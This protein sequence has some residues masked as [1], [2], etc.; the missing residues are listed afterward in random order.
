MGK[1][2]G[3]A[4]DGGSQDME[5][6]GRAAGP[7]RRPTSS[8]VGRSADL[9]GVLGAIQDARLVTLTGPGGVGKTR[10]A[11]EVM[12]RI[13][14]AAFD[15]GAV[16]DLSELDDPTLIASAVT[17]RLGLVVP[18]DEVSVADALV[19]SLAPGSQVLVL[20]NCEHL[21]GAVTGLVDRLLGSSA[22]LR[23]LVTSRQ[24]LRVPGEIVWRVDPLPVPGPD[25]GE[26]AADVLPVPSGGLFVDRA[27]AASHRF[28]LD[29]T[30]APAVAAICRRLDGLPLAIELA[31]AWTSSLSPGE[32]DERLRRDLDFLRSPPGAPRRHETLRAV[33]A[34]SY[35]QLT[36]REKA[37][38]DR[39]GPFTGFSADAAQ[40][41]CGP[42]LGDSDEITEVLARLVDKSLVVVGQHGGRAR[43]RRLVAARVFGWELLEGLS[44]AGPVR[45]RHAEWFADLAEAS[46]ADPSAKAL[47]EVEIE[48]D[49]FSAA[50]SWA[51]G[52]ETAL[53]LRLFS[54]LRPFWQTGGRVGEGRR[55]AEALLAPDGRPAGGAA[56]DPA[57]LGTAQETAGAL[58]LDVGDHDPARTWLEAA[59][60][61]FRALED[62]AGTGRALVNL[63]VLARYRGELGE[64]ERLLREAAGL[65]RG[66]PAEAACLAELGQ[67]TALSG[68]E[69]EGERILL[70]ALNLARGRGDATA[71]ADA[72][73][74]LGKLAAVRGALDVAERHHL[75][76]LELHREMRR[77]RAEART[78]G[79]L[80][81]IAWRK[82]EFERGQ[83]LYEDALAVQRRL[84]DQRGMAT[85][86]GHLA[87]IAYQRG[88]PLESADLNRQ[89]VELRRRMGDRRGEGVALAGLATAIWLAE[90]SEIELEEARSLV[91]RA[92]ELQ[93]G[94]GDRRALAWA[95]YCQAEIARD[96]GHN[97]VARAA[98]VEGLGIYRQL[99]EPASAT[100][101]LHTLATLAL[102][103]GA[104]P[105]ARTLLA[106][107]TG[108]ALA[109][110]LPLQ[111]LRCVEVGAHVS[112]VEGRTERSAVLYGAADAGREAL[113]QGRWPR[114]VQRA[115]A[116]EDLAELR[117]RLGPAA[118]AALLEQGRLLSIEQACGAFLDPDMDPAHLGGAVES[119]D[120][121][122]VWSVRLMGDVVVESDGR[123]VP[124]RGRAPAQLV[125][126]VALRGRIHADELIE[127]IWPDSAPGVGRRRLNNLLARLR[128][129]TGALVERQGD[130]LGLAPGA[131]LDVD[132]FTAAAE[133]A[134]AAVGGGSP[135]AAALC[136]KA[137][138]LYQGELLPADR[139]DDWAAAPRVRLARLHLDV[140]DA[141]AEEA[142]GAGRPGEAVQWFERGIDAEPLDLARY[143]RVAAL[144]VEQGWRHRARA[145]ALRAR[146]VSDE[147]N[148]GL[149]A[150]LGRL[151]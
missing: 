20:D 78:L 81:E 45:R 19:A 114:R 22:G 91:D 76:A 21:I 138:T 128:R 101:A 42:A 11:H 98:S 51:A 37:V 52:E 23:I 39:L 41:V 17:E 133:A 32:I 85:S 130:T 109:M 123:P 44:D 151:L 5:G 70:R 84:G 68:R 143:Q 100:F 50:L 18:A 30:N 142:A 74:D 117:R 13:D 55:W 95:L 57:L 3:M 77:L 139:Y 47:R 103:D 12:E 9:Q 73:N 113:D 65:L 107:A 59:V 83:S 4:V 58:A 150:D 27:R 2:V 67:V 137:A 92:V 63:G 10:L 25:S 56:V 122:P 69:A 115:I 53:A 141:L 106:E 88:R 116:E 125:K 64:A 131:D 118:L 26:S 1:I 66:Q 38:F 134:L 36:D 127:L 6:P 71:A 75:Q 111:Q 97:D 132:A 144:L 104:V 87:S 48:H 61:A 49:N 79:H 62:G 29:D 34:H 40:A 7:R 126:I 14:V 135:E 86:L 105:E 90:P 124:L 120:S 8:F 60:S 35:A 54:A 89:L 149:P 147:L 72:L 28:R 108:L 148:V 119:P 102:S 140:L 80:G 112:F 15:G 43:Y 121:G 110:G 145:L 146:R 136:R 24:P 82:R 94:T 33:F 129:E 46:L 16:V 99:G 31:A 96:Q 93:R